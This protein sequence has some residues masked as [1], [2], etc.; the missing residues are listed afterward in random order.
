M[1]TDQTQRTWRVAGLSVVVLLLLITVLYW[2]TLL[3]LTSLW[4]EVIIGE[5]AHGYL[6]VAI[7]VYL[8]LRNRRTLLSLK[9]CPEYRALP[10]VLAASLLWTVAALVDVEMMQ[11]AGLLL[12]VLA[13]VWATLGN[14]ATWALLFPI[15]FIGFAI[16]IWFPLSPLLQNLT[17]DTVFGIIRMLGVPALRQENVIVLPAGSLSIEEACSGLRYLMAAMTLGTLYA[18]LNYTSFRARLVVVLVSAGAGVLANMLRVFIVVYLG[19]ATD[20]QHP[21]VH[22]HL[23]LGWYL[24]G[25]LVA[26]LLFLDARVHRHHQNTSDINTSE[27]NSVESNRCAKGTVRYLSVIIAVAALLSIGPA[28]VYRF[29]HQ[30]QVDSG[31]IALVLPV[32]KSGWMGP[33]DS[34]NDWTPVYN[35]AITRKQ[36]YIKDSERVTVYIG[37][38]P[39]QRQG[40]ELINDLNRISNKEFWRTRH[41]HAGLREINRQPVLEQQLEKNNGAKQL[42]WYWYRVAGRVT[43]NK[44]EAK[45]LQVLGMISGKP[46]SFVIAVATDTGEDTANARTVLGGFLLAMGPSFTEVMTKSR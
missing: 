8:I 10:A 35:G 37:Y 5:Y 17:A 45:V 16:P 7:S 21:L 15:L 30:T 43:T 27:Q 12:M 19:Y 42:V 29:H 13:V 24:F 23:M 28:V 46:Q 3:Y 33:V 44:Y 18:Y 34:K 6:V 26:V 25:G 9:P 14:K 41:A 20:M 1:S 40:E 39:S 36:N 38:Y 2:Q 4:N 11:S 32:G 22:D 31:S